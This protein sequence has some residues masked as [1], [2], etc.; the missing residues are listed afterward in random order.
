MTE[1]TV[2]LDEVVVAVLQAPRE[3]GA[4]GTAE[5]ALRGPAHDVD[6]TEVLTDLFGQVRGAVGTAVVDHQHV[7]LRHDLSQRAQH[8]FHVHDLVVRGQNHE[9]THRTTLP[10]GQYD[11]SG[12]LSGTV[13]TAHLRYCYA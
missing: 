5:S 11:D 8:R 6:L 4:V 12:A 1:V 9:R 7:A 2:D 3:A 10:R 13:V